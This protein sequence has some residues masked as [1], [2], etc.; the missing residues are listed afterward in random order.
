MQNKLVGKK[1]FSL[2]P[3]SRLKTVGAH[4]VQPGINKRFYTL[5]FKNGLGSQKQLFLP[6]KILLKL[7]SVTNIQLIT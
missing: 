3:W 2:D 4:C 5:L 6:L 1:V 7:I